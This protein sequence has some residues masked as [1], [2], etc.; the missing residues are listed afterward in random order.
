MNDKKFVLEA[1]KK[2]LVKQLA[3]YRKQFA[4]G[5]E[6]VEDEQRYVLKCARTIRE[7]MQN[8]YS[9]VQSVEILAELRDDIYK[10]RAEIESASSRKID[11]GKN[12]KDR[13]KLLKIYENAYVRQLRRDTEKHIN[14]LMMTHL[15]NDISKEKNKFMNFIP[16]GLGCEY[17]YYLK[18]VFEY[19][20][21]FA[22]RSDKIT[23]DQFVEYNLMCED[24]YIDSTV[25]ELLSVENMPFTFEFNPYK[26]LEISMEELERFKDDVVM[27]ME[28]NAECMKKKEY[29]AAIIDFPK[30]SDGRF[31]GRNDLDELFNR[32]DRYLEAFDSD[33][34][35]LEPEDIYIKLHGTKEVSSKSKIVASYLGYANRYIKA[36][37]QGTF[38]HI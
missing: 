19:Q 2:C 31:K 38:P 21:K 25:D 20:V 3:L 27:L 14:A 9:V 18:R 1:L 36:V 13:N 5:N 22:Q 4:T 35:G 37:E 11:S 30:D 34:S 17:V 8:P 24:E 26:P 16:N 15:G 29:I 6:N 32:W 7:V 28:F 10:L 12:I 23:T 33:E